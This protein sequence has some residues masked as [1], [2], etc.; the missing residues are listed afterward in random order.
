MIRRYLLIGL[1]VVGIAG[2]ASYGAWSNARAAHNAGIASCQTVNDS[3]VA[4]VKF[5]RKSIARPGVPAT[6]QATAFVDGLE[7]NDRKVFADCLAKVP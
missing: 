6:T 5:L 1:V 2:L 7:R 4:L 3:N